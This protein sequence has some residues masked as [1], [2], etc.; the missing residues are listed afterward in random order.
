MVVWVTN[1]FPA[2]E[3]QRPL[4]ENLIEDR[5]DREA[6]PH[7]GVEGS[8]PNSGQTTDNKRSP[9]QILGE[10]ENDATTRQM[11]REGEHRANQDFAGLSLDKPEVSPNND[12]NCRGFNVSL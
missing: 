8:G 11:G 12:G 5:R 2:Y 4:L 1:I 7:G 9:T 6:N 10:Q 3:K